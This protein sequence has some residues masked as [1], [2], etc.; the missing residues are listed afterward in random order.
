M[1]GFRLEGMFNG[2]FGNE[3]EMDGSTYTRIQL[4]DF[5]KEIFAQRPWLGYGVCNF[6]A[7]YLSYFPGRHAL[8]A[9]NNYIE[10]LVDLGIVGL[11]LYYIFYIYLIVRLFKIAKKQ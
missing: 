1:I 6:R 10:L 4:V 8:Y 9:H 2:F 11:V 7:V 5:G 3:E